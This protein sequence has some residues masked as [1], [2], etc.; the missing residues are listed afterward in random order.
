MRIVKGKNPRTARM[1]FILSSEIAR[2]IKKYV[3]EHLALIE[4][5]FNSTEMIFYM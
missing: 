1:T 3:T 2:R 5:S 4:V